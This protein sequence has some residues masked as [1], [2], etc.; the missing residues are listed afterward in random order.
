MFNTIRKGFFAGSGSAALS[1]ISVVDKILQLTGKFC[2]ATTM[3]QSPVRVVYLGTATYDLQ[4]PRDNQTRCFHARGC[5]IVSL[6]V[7]DCRN[8]PSHSTLSDALESADVVIV[9]GGNTL[10]AVKRWREIGVD[11]LIK[12]A[13]ARGA[14]MTGG[15]AGAICW[16]DGGHSD[17]MDPETYREY[18]LRAAGLLPPTAATTMTTTSEGTST[19]EASEA[20]VGAPSKS[21]KYIRISGLGL[22]PGLLCPH[23]DRTQSNGRPRYADFDEML[24]RHQG[25]RG[26]V[27]DHWAALV[28]EEG[29]YHVFSTPNK[30]GSCVVVAAASSSSDAA[31]PQDSKTT[32]S[33]FVTDGSGVP[34][35]WWKEVI[36]GEVVRHSV[37]FEGGSLEELLKQA[38]SIDLDPLEELCAAENPTQY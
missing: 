29:R 26:I 33:T 24:L 20:P 14:V 10:F 1:E 32:T 30:E 35:V 31:A 7:A 38:E 16:F 25:E 2:T 3:L 5:S 27:I 8:T 11:V 17:S 15:S 13:A 37:P 23:H 4:P 34:A 9:S 36:D 28:V 19:D 21:W 6:D 12:N 18:M 22:L